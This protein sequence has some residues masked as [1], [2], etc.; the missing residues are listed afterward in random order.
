MANLALNLR[1]V[2]QFDEARALFARSLELDP[3]RPRILVAWAQLEID[4]RQ[5]DA[6]AAVLARAVAAGGETKWTA[7]IR[8]QLG[9]LR[10]NLQGALAAIDAM[11]ADATTAER[12]ELILRKGRLLDRLGRPGEAWQ[13]FVAGKELGRVETHKVFDGAMVENLTS[14]LAGF[15]TADRRA[16]LP[17]A[18]ARGDLAQPIFIMGFPRSGTTLLE[19][20][21]SMHPRI[22]A[23]DELH[24]IRGISNRLP[25]LLQSPL[26]YPEA[27]SELWMADRRREIDGLRD[28]YLRGVPM[29][30]Q[31]GDHMRWFI[32]K[33]P[34]NEMHIGLIALMF[35]QAPMLHLIRHPLDV[36]LSVYSHYL[37]HGFNC[38][39]QLQTIAQLYAWTDQLV[40]HYGAELRPRYRA[41]RYE[42]LIEDQEG[43]LRAVFDFLGEQFDPACLEFHRNARVARTASVT[44]VRE[45]LYTRS[46]YRYR[47]YLSQLEPVIPILAPSIARLGY[48]V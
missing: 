28:L 42:R 17:R 37:T 8:V 13:H 47:N 16:T 10:G 48:T 33:T 40:A 34:L 27:L 12:V 29:L 35:P 19:T 24:L 11:M 36:V 21:L 14:R 7:S 1:L 43:E 46:C 26:T 23:G 41:V 32:D 2:G 44:Q 22:A 5:P 39:F 20:S 30:D 45:Q 6:A 18:R 15:F 25:A 9:E 31:L 38:A 3:H 4:A